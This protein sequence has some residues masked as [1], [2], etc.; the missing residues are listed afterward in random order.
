MSKADILLREA[1]RDLEIGCYNKAVSAVYFAVRMELETLA[2]KL[3]GNVPRRDDKL[4]NVLKHLG[5]EE[6]ALDALYLY[7]RR[8]DADYGSQSLDERLARKC[9]ILGRKI[10]MQIRDLH[11]KL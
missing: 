4:I 8:K 6:L 3:G 1:E 2:R 5:K 7:E 9:L 11:Q 10:I